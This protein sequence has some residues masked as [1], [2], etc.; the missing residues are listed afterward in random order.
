[1][2]NAAYIPNCIT[3]LRLL[4]ILPIVVGLLSHHEQL[5]FWLFVIAG[6][7]DAV[8]GYLARRFHWI[9]RFGAMVDPLADKLLMVSTV[10]TLSYLK[11]FPLWLLIVIISRELVIVTG[12]FLYHFL[13]GVYEFSPTLLSK[14]NTG[15]QII[16]VITIMADL[17]YTFIP[18]L[19]MKGLM[20][21]VLMTS[22]LSLAQYVWIWGQR[23]WQHSKQNP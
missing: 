19:L 13:I 2:M 7:T 18:P 23:A 8:D 10:L 11:L 16:L 21:L 5:S 20:V 12:A 22:G 6:I 1:M 4:L 9:S 14:W 15:L 3:V 17:S